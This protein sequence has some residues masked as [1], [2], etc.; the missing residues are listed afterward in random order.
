MLE[1][2]HK[3]LDVWKQSMELAQRIYRITSDFPPEEKFGLVSQMRRAAVS[4][5]SNIA[6][7]AARQGKREFNK[8][9][10]IA[11]GSLSELDTQVE[12]SVLLGYLSHEATG[13]LSGQLTRIDQMLAGLI[14]KL[15][16]SSIKRRGKR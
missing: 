12:L 4:I 10:G 3:R 6:E 9:L 16:E 5:P 13:E 14:R 15:S 8:F 7:G 11:R 2:P 1:K